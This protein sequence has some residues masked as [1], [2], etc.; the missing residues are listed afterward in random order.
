MYTDEKFNN[1]LKLPA[2]TVS[3]EIDDDPKNTRDSGDFPYNYASHFLAGNPGT[4]YWR[5]YHNPSNKIEIYAAFI[6]K[7]ITL[8][9]KYLFPDIRSRDDMYNWMTNI[10]RYGGPPVNFGTKMSIYSAI[11]EAMLDY[12]SVCEGYNL[13]NPDLLNLFNT[14]LATYSSGLLRH[15]KVTMRDASSMWFMV[16]RLPKMKIFAENRPDKGEGETQ[17]QTKSKFELTETIECEPYFP[18]MFITYV[19]ETVHQQIT[20]EQ[21]KPAVLSPSKGVDGRIMNT[22]NVEID[23]T[24]LDLNMKSQQI[25]ANIEF[26]SSSE[27]DD[28]IPI[29]EEIIPLIHQKVIS[30]VKRSKGCV[31]D[32]YNIYL[33]SF[34]N[35][36]K[37]GVDYEINWDT[38]EIA[39]HNMNTSAI[40]RLITVGNKQAIKPYMDGITIHK[41]I[42]QGEI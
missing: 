40:Y 4:Y 15:K 32:Y 16:Y 30:L 20:P 27:G 33:Y 31:S 24:I 34:N 19:P 26:G 9:I 18:Q 38:M 29:D 10:F 11:P 12:I 23:P 25:L 13:K 28:L 41:E 37:E 2:C 42:Q 22:R 5:I 8:T 3:Y 36:L 21:Y 7:K 1:A 39:F 6:R 35:K 17:G 14:E